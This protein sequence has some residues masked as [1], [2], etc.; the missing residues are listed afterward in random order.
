MN[1]G[2]SDLQISASPAR[3]IRVCPGFCFAPAVIMTTSASLQT[4][5]SLDPSIVALTDP[6]PT[7]AILVVR[8]GMIGENFN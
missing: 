1:C 3:S 7:I 4:F 5:T 8:S 6:A 2:V